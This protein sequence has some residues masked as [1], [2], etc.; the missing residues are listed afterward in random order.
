MR[1]FGG[2]S[3]PKRAVYTVDTLR[4]VRA[5]LA[6]VDQAYPVQGAGKLLTLSNPK[7][8]RAAAEMGYLPA[9]LHLAPHTMA[10]VN[11]CA[12]ASVECAAGCLNTSGQGGIGL[13]AAGWN[14]TQAARIRRTAS[15]A[16]EPGA[17]AVRLAREIGQHAARAA[18][19]GLT[20]CLR[21][22]GTSDVTW[23][24]TF[25]DVLLA[26]R[27]AGVILYDYTKRPT[28]DAAEHGI[29][30]TYSYP[31]GSGTAA[32]RYLQAGHRVAVVFATVRGR[33]LKDQAL[34]AEWLAPWGETFPV[35][36]G[37]AHDLRFTDPGGVII[38]LR[39]KGK[40]IGAAPSR[41]GFVQAGRTLAA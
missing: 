16:L 39:A 21:L 24:R 15:L 41:K 36:D 11:V 13:D 26:A 34:P 38:G 20:P 9:I 4:T 5:T 25:P 22:N 29:D 35:H 40:L 8:N 18:R 37:D 1:H 3:M 19:M 12:W 33:R 23:H 17:F 2:G 6:A 14:R 32:R 27:E 31:G 28:P 7:V 10:G 30:V